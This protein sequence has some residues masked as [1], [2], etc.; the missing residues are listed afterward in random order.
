MAL[1]HLEQI[2]HCYMSFEVTLFYE[3]KIE[4]NQ[5][6]IWLFSDRVEYLLAEVII[7]E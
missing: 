5:V 4:S 7:A 1:F 3:I 6:C 2:K